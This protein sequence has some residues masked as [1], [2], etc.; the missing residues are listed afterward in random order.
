MCEKVYHFP[1]RNHSTYDKESSLTDSR[2]TYWIYP[3]K[4]N[5]LNI[6]I[7]CNERNDKSHGDMYPNMHSH[8][9]SHHGFPNVTFSNHH[10]PHERICSLAWTVLFLRVY[11][12]S[13]CCQLYSLPRSCSVFLDARVWHSL[14]L[15]FDS[16][17]IKSVLKFEGNHAKISLPWLN[18]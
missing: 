1:Y 6:S 3:S 9:E 4:K 11:W 16:F 17:I 18:H 7:W 12:H 15:C 8:S 2:R 14:I 13:F 5:I 10:V